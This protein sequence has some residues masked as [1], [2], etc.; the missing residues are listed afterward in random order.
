MNICSTNVEI[1][2]R[3]QTKQRRE[4]DQIAGLNWGW[5]NGKCGT[6]D[7]RIMN[8]Y[9]DSCVFSWVTDVWRRSSQRLRTTDASQLVTWRGLSSLVD[10]APHCLPKCKCSL[11]QR[12]SS[13]AVCFDIASSCVILL[14][15]SIFINNYTYH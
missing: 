7:V 9:I 3:A 11:P 1:T 4:H 10:Y 12:D 8:A 6:T 2:H 14:I 15:I 5:D 13:S